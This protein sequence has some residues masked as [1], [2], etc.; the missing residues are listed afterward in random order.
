[1]N[2]AKRIEWID[3]AKGISIILMII[4]HTINGG[5]RNFIYSFHMPL[6]IILSGYTIKEIT[7]VHQLKAN[8]VKDFKRLIIPF[9]II[10]VIDVSIQT[11]IC[12]RSLSFGFHEFIRRF[13]TC[14]N[15]EWMPV[16]FLLMLFW[17][18]TLYYLVECFVNNTLIIYVLLALIGIFVPNL[19]SLPQYFDVALV[20]TLF[21]YFGVLFKNNQDFISKHPAI[22]TVISLILWIV[23]FLFDIHIEIAVRHYPYSVVC[24]IEAIA[25]A[26]CIIM[27]SKCI[28]NHSNFVRR[29]SSKI[30]TCTLLILC[31]HQMDVM[32]SSLWDYSDIP[33][34][35]PLF[36]VAFDLTITLLILFIKNRFSSNDCGISSKES[37]N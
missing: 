7:N 11:I 1:M 6:F 34:L 19:C 30:G 21:L 3:T 27:F 28:A 8:V 22:T 9:A 23:P 4:G 37:S 32:F 18:K 36:R 24:V 33:W 12:G 17:A 13:I 25:G 29:I 10:N 16:W 14:D 26:F 15:L 31:V 2:S 20:G 35:A 5:M